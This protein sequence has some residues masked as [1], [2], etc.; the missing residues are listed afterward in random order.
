MRKLLLPGLL[1]MA[2]FV[3]CENKNP[4][5]PAGVGP[6]GVTVTQTT[7]STTSTSTTSSIPATTTTSTTSTTTTVTGS[8]SRRY[9]A[10]QAPPNVPADMTLFFQLLTGGGIVSSVLE[11]LTI[12][13]PPNTV[14]ENEY[15][16]TGVYVMGNGVSGRV[17]GELGDALNPLETGGVFDGNLTANMPAGCIAEREFG[18]ALGPQTLD[19]GGGSTLRDCPGSPLSFQSFS[20]LRSDAP[21]PS[22]TTVPATTTVP[23]TSSSTSSSTSTTTTSTAVVC[24]YTL[25]PTSATAPAEGTTGQVVI[26]TLPT[27]PWTAQSFASWLTVAPPSG[28]GPGS[29]TYTAAANVNGPARTGTLVIAGLTF[30]VSQAAPPPPDLTPVF[31]ASTSPCTFNSDTGQ[32]T[33]TVQATNAGVGAAPVSSLARITFTTGPSSI[34]DQTV[35][36]LAP[37]AQVPLTFVLPA[38]CYDDPDDGTCAL[39]ITLDATGAVFESNEGNNT[40]Q[41]NCFGFNEGLAGR[42]R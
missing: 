10:F 26:G 31:A 7:S 35:G 1:L 30:T 38:T 29:V 41:R 5:G 42:R 25:A 4:A 18:G 32:G 22:T 19:W 8:L 27:C 28:A 20:L 40:I 12:L 6:G 39:T 37:K 9:V 34:P 11:T 16:V 17:D 36:L 13:G 23:T 14:T 2:L 24:S 33:V 21:L 3:A 15:K